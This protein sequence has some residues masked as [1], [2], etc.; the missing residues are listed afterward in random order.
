MQGK[1]LLY[2]SIQGSSIVFNRLKYKLNA[3]I[4]MLSLLVPI[5]V[6]YLLPTSH[7]K[8]QNKYSLSL[9]AV[10]LEKLMKIG[11]TYPEV[12]TT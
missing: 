12:F 3:G 2:L 11:P 4:Q 6:N 9:H 5:L 8:S 7:D 10:S 1:Y